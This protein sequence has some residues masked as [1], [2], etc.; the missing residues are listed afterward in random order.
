MSGAA[1]RPRTD[2][3]GS[4]RRRGEARRRQGWV[5]GVYPSA[6]LTARTAAFDG[7]TAFTRAARSAG[8]RFAVILLSKSMDVERDHLIHRKR[9]PFPYEGK[10][11]MRSNR[12][13]TASVGRDTSYFR[14]LS[15]SAQNAPRRG[16][17][18]PGTSSTTDAVPLPLEGKDLTRRSVGE[19]SCSECDIFRYFSLTCDINNHKEQTYK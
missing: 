13:E 9:S 15:A 17:G 2:A 16:A 7:Q 11:L 8:L 12:S 1:S 5:G 3:P 14:L 18:L 6:P 10:D 19:T 4:E